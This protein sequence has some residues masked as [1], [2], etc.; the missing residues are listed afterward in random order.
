MSTSMRTHDNVVLDVDR[1]DAYRIALEFCTLAGRIRP[2]LRELRDQLDRAS[3]S[4]VLN[5]AE[6]V[7]RPSTA[8]R[9]HFFAIARGSA[10][11]CVAILDVLHARGV[12]VAQTHTDGRVLL[13]R[14]VRMLTRLIR[15]SVRPAQRHSPVVGSQTQLLE[16]RVNT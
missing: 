1:L 5:T 8:D 12:L 6:A 9:A 3:S 16:P 4:I 11:E 13:T 10:L 7:G 15:P 14:V 2:A